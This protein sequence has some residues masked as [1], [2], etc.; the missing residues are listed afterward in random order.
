MELSDNFLDGT[1]TKDNNGNP[2]FF[3]INEAIISKLCILGEDQEPCFEGAGIGSPQLQFSFDKEFKE[4]LFSMMKELKDLIKGGTPMITAYAVELGGALW[5]ALYSYLEANQEQENVAPK[6]YVDSFWEEDE[7]KYVVLKAREDGKTYRLNF[8]WDETSFVANEEMTEIETISETYEAFSLDAI[9]AYENEKYKKE[10]N[11]GQ[12]DN[13]KIDNSLEGKNNFVKEE[14]DEEKCPKCGKPKSEC[15]CE[16]EDEEE[17]NK[18]KYSLEDI[19]E[20][21]ELQNKYSE[22]EKSFELL[23]EEKEQVDKELESLTSF[24]AEIDRKEKQSMIDGFYMLSDEDKKDVID[25]IDTYSLDEIESKLS[26]ICVRKKVNFNLEEEQEKTAEPT[27]YSL[28]GGG[29][30]SFV[31]AWIKSLQSVAKDIDN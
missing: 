5:T 12:M 4:E 29:E 8:S 28:N 15:K 17:K 23:K 24:K 10:D 13:D 2:K 1:W 14:D 9:A 20:Y 6:Y 25:N 31:P 22:L 3:I 7:Q 30:E 16:D 26:V 18:K 11:S 19:P 27:T 21:I